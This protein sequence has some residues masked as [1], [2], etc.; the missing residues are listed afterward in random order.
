M[1]NGTDD[2]LGNKTQLNRHQL[3]VALVCLELHPVAYI[4][5]GGREKQQKAM[6][7]RSVVEETYR[8]RG[9]SNLFD[10]FIAETSPASPA[11]RRRTLKA[12]PK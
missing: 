3:C 4:E 12:L 2:D 11:S 7:Q 10:F 9:P 1:H 5:K 6:N 8:C